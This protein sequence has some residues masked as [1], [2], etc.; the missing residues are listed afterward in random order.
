MWA[1]GK[2]HLVLD[3]GAI[4]AKMTEDRP[5]KKEAKDASRIANISAVAPADEESVDR[6]R[7]RGV[8]RTID[9][10]DGKIFPRRE[11]RPRYA[12]SSKAN[13]ETINGRRG[14]AKK[15]EA[16]LE[17]LAW[18]GERRRLWLV[19]SHCRS[20]GSLDKVKPAQ[21][22]KRVRR[23]LDTAP[24]RTLLG[25]VPLRDDGRP[26]ANSGLALPLDD[27]KGSL[28]TAIESE[29]GYLA[30]ALKWPAKENG[31][32]I[33]GIAVDDTDILLG[34]RGPAAGGFAIVMRLSVEI[35]KKALSLRK[36]NGHRYRLSFLPLNGLGIRRRAR[37][38]WAEH[39]PRRS[40]RALPLAWRLRP[41]LRK[42]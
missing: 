6:I 15:P 21:L 20:R 14:A 16:D 11:L 8:A 37:A 23:I 35:G 22:R 1:S 38:C 9:T 34:L 13:N 28:R 10:R 19:G 40:V 12:V 18:D 31:L 25:F 26:L 7:R 4:A 32:D 5:A 17:G 41:R 2:D 42:G 30:E 27:E 24:L 39:G 3:Y 36:R 29:G 33:E